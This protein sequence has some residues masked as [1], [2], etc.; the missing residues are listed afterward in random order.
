M[1]IYNDDTHDDNN[2]SNKKEI[3]SSG[4][5]TG[6]V[7]SSPVELSSASQ[8]LSPSSYIHNSSIITTND[9]HN[10][11]SDGY[12]CNLFAD[13]EYICDGVKEN[14]V[15]LNNRLVLSSDKADASILVSSLYDIYL[16]IS[17]LIPSRI[18]LQQNILSTIQPLYLIDLISN[19]ACNPT[20]DLLPILL[21][22]L[23]IL[24]E[25]QAPTKVMMIDA[26]MKELVVSFSNESSSSRGKSMDEVAVLLPDFFEKATMIIED[27]KL[28]VSPFI[29][30]MI[31]S[32][33]SPSFASSLLS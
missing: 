18:D 33:L 5:D 14:K 32:F 3:D 6:T 23:N 1:A 7:L 24:K 8:A 19:R 10:H 11:N 26:W 31:F 15:L 29:M 25:L 27:I 16:Q 9:N 20:M 17:S 21:Y 12:N 28:D 2:H 22:L 4:D 13:V 30:I